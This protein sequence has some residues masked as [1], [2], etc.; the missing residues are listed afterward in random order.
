[1]DSLRL[2]ESI[3]HKDYLYKKVKSTPLHDSDYEYLSDEL[4]RYEKILKHLIKVT[5]SNYFNC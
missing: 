1:M 5:K 4:S 2:I 3:K